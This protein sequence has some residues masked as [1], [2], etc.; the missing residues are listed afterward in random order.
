MKLSYFLLLLKVEIFFLFLTNKAFY[1][2]LII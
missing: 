1:L 2:N